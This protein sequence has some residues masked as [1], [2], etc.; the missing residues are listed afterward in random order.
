[1]MVMHSQLILLLLLSAVVL[2]PYA[3]GHSVVDIEEVQAA[4]Y[5]EQNRNDDEIVVPNHHQSEYDINHEEN[6]IDLVADSSVYDVGSNSEV[7]SEAES[8]LA[9]AVALEV[10]SEVAAALASGESGA[11]EAVE[12]ENRGDEDFVQELEEEKRD[13][14]VEVGASEQRRVE[15][16]VEDPEQ[17]E[18]RHEERG[19]DEVSIQLDEELHLSVEDMGDNAQLLTEG[20]I[21]IGREI[22]PD[23]EDVHSFDEVSLD[24]SLNHIISEILLGDI[25]RDA[26]VSH[27]KLRDEEA[28]ETGPGVTV[29][30]TTAP[31]PSA[32]HEETL[33]EI[34]SVA[35]VELQA[36]DS[37]VDELGQDAAKAA[38]FVQEE[39]SDADKANRRVANQYLT[40]YRA[41][42]GRGTADKAL[43]ELGKAINRAPSYAEPYVLRADLLLHSGDFKGAVLDHLRVVELTRGGNA[44]SFE[45]SQTICEHMLALGRVADVKPLLGML[46]SANVSSQRSGLLYADVLLQT[47]QESAALEVYERYPMDLS[48]AAA[49]LKMSRLYESVARIA[50]AERIMLDARAGGLL[51]GA[52]V[53]DFYSRVNHTAEAI[54]Y[55]AAEFETS[56]STTH[57]LTLGRLYERLGDVV[58]AAEYF[59]EALAR[60]EVDPNMRVFFARHDEFSGNFTSHTPGLEILQ[61]VAGK[62]GAQRHRWCVQRWAQLPRTPDGSKPAGD[63]MRGLRSLGS[64]QQQ[65][66]AAVAGVEGMSEFERLQ[67]ELGVEEEEEMI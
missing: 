59:E 29:T 40:M 67:G 30:P 61:R 27:E 42:M 52:V 19:K 22:R 16:A 58:H 14:V 45:Q 35:T 11:S 50:E 54:R 13:E 5:L 43:K 37:A 23:G 18:L 65:V 57:L 60:G 9:E 51:D 38:N 25:N 44:T 53:G 31:D 33:E 4:E 62:G 10:A 66:E 6:H 1:M 7:I 39:L 8:E 36:Q 34:P 56:N 24:G 46:H 28:R 41:Y 3:Y 17:T 55:F 64:K 2:D 49:V 63:S 32:A 47:G 15:N 12:V 48:S 20:V 21:A 26:T